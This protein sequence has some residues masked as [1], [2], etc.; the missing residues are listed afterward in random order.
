MLVPSQTILTAGT[1]TLVAN[2]PPGP[3]A[4][5]LINNGGAVVAI[6]SSTAVTVAA[7]G[8]TPAGALIPAGVAITLNMPAGAAPTTLY[9]IS[10]PVG[11]ISTFI[12]TAR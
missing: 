2:V 5:T 6:G 8:T 4:V 10:T 9:G 12:V 7:S 1:V 3:V 11:T